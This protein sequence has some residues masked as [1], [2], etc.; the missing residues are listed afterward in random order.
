MNAMAGGTASPPKDI[1]RAGATPI[2]IPDEEDHRH[3]SRH[4]DVRG[5][6]TIRIGGP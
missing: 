3:E 2:R 1:V 6:V 4:G 5:D